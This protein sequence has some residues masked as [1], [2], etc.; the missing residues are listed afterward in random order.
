MLS[1]AERRTLAE[2]EARVHA[3]DP[4]L[5]RLLSQRPHPESTCPAQPR[6]GR[7]PLILWLLVAE[8]V[9]VLILGI[10]LALGQ[11]HLPPVDAQHI[12]PD[13]R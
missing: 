1:P 9:M 6:R 10:A 12:P 5:A 2:I 3:N 4:E 11:V 13:G 7:W 8:A